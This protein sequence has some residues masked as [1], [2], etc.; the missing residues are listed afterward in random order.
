VARNNRILIKLRGVGFGK[1]R[2]IKA[3]TYRIFANNAAKRAL[4]TCAPGLW[5]MSE[6]V[7]AHAQ[8]SERRKEHCGEDN[9]GRDLTVPSGQIHRPPPSTNWSDHM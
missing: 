2:R 8:L 3:W 4:E 9:D 6:Y 7:F 1:V 5:Q